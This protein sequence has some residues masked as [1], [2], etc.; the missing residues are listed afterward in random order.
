VLYVAL[1]AVTVALGAGTYA[2]FMLGRWATYHRFKQLER[3]PF[4][5]GP[6]TRWLRAELWS[7]VMLGWWSLTAG[8]RDG[9]LEPDGAPT[10]PPVLCIHGITQ[11]GSNFWG[12]R[13]ELRRRGRPTRAVS[14]GRVRRSLLA[15]VPPVAAVLREM[16]ADGPIDVVAHSMGGIV[17]R[18]ALAQNPEIA[19]RIRRV[20]T[21]ASPHFGT[22]AGRGFRFV[23]TVGELGRRSA[24]LR[25]LPCFSDGTRVT[26]FAAGRDIVVY[27]LQT[28]HLPGARTIDL[29][30]SGHTGLLTQTSAIRRIA[31]DVC[32]E[33]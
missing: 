3:P 26:T 21:L 4:S 32:D 20:I 5:W 6:F 23:P 13:Q 2:L 17:L 28:C 8:R 27:P 7:F 19:P 11:A 31:D 10:G 1:A 14:Y 18:L 15:H 16:T 29:P 30:D 24:T 12:L 33:D 9:L 25:D 22:A